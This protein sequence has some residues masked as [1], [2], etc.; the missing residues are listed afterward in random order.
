MLQIYGIN[1][2]HDLKI[3]KKERDK[4]IVFSLPAQ[5]LSYQLAL[6]LFKMKSLPIKEKSDI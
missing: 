6:Q 1:E 5:V 4:S 3:S 2:L